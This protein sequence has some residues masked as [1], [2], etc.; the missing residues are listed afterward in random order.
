MCVCGGGGHTPRWT[1]HSQRSAVSRCCCRCTGRAL[2]PPPP[3]PHCTALLCSGP[4]PACTALP[5]DGGEVTIA[6][7]G[8]LLLAD[9][10]LSRAID[11]ALAAVECDVEGA[12]DDGG[13]GGGGGGR[14]GQMRVLYPEGRSVVVPLPPPG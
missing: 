8:R 2:L 5:Q 4:R 12:G 3:S 11:G 6:C 9:V 7:G 14:R 10:G 13:G 1:S